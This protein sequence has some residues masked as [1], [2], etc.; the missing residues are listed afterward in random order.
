MIRKFKSIARQ[1]TPPFLYS[2]AKRVW[3]GIRARVSPPAPAPVDP[4]KVE[5]DRLNTAAAADEIVFREGL[6][7]KIHPD[8]RVPFEYFCHLDAAVVR[9]MDCF[10]D[11]TRS[12]SR[13]LDVGAL[14][15]VFSLVFA[16]GDA[17]RQVVAVDASPIAY[18]RLLYNIHKNDLSNIRPVECALSSEPGVLQMHYEWEHAVAAPSDRPGRAQ[19]SVR[20]MTGDELC[21]GLAFHPDAIKID[22]EGHEVKVV[23]GLAGEIHRSRPL[24]F[25]E[26]HPARIAG[27]NDSIADMVSI[28]RSAR[29]EAHFDDG[30]P[31]DLDALAGSSLPVAR[32]Y[33]APLA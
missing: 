12:C 32:L 21:A 1:V 9:E 11:R 15:G 17:R 3:F 25:L 33:L 6:K 24:V 27:E 22:V 29:Y 20:K 7:L 30:T 31:I 13:L 28:F 10:I 16:A 26:V 14:H 18:A 23:K 8:S 5:F 19:L 2:A 4:L